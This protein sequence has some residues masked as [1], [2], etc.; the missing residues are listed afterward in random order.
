MNCAHVRLFCFALSALLVSSPAGAYIHFPPMTLPKLCKTSTHIRVL[1]VKKHDP[2]RGVVIFELVET[3]KG[4]E[5]RMNSIRHVIRA[6]A[7][8]IKPIRD[9]AGDGKRAV[10]FS[11]E[12]DPRSTQMGCAYV[13]I[14]NYCYSLDYNRSGE[15]WALVRAEP[16]MS[17]CY[18]GSVEQLQRLTKDL[19]DGK[20][21]KVPT[22]EPPSAETKE[23]RDRRV[24]EVTEAL[25]KNRRK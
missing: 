11:I 10:M 23:D 22:K 12:A 7:E 21:V 19:L 2:D 18:H 13:F 25:N 4:Q 15:Y 5:P 6:E 8:G 17:A 24:K 14:D 3:L 16:N 9:W 20:D 1:R